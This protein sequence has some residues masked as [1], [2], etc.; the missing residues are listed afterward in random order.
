MR[1]RMQS[2]P[3]RELDD[4]STLSTFVYCH[5]ERRLRVLFAGVSG[6]VGNVVD[7]LLKYCGSPLL[8]SYGSIRILRSVEIAMAVVTELS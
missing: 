6:V 1:T 7:L 3:R 8:S 5:R 2:T 4:R